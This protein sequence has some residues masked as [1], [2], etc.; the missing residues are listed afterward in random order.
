MRVLL[1][2]D[3]LPNVGGAERYI[4]CVRDGLRAAGD[5]VKLLTSTAGTAGD[6][7]AEYRAF[8]SDR[9]AAKLVLQLVNP[10]AIVAVRSALR[11]FRPDVALV[12]MFEHQL[13]PAVL[14]ALRGVPTVLCVSDYKGICPVST[15]LLPNGRICH[16]RDGLICWR[17]GCVSLPHWVRDQPRY[18]L[19]RSGR[20]G[21][22]RIL[23]C[24]RWVQRELALSGVEAEH[25]TLPV[26]A[27]GPDFRRAPAADPMFVFCGRL[28]QTKGVA[29]LLRAFARLRSTAPAAR[30][31]IVGTGP[32]RDGLERLAGVLGLAEAVTF[33]G[34]VR[35]AEVAREIADAWALVVPSL[36]AEPLGL[37]AIE[38]TVRGI[39]VVASA[40]GGL[41]EIVEHGV[42]G[43][44]FPNGDEEALAERLASI[45]AGAAFPRHTVS[46]AIVR[47]TIEAHDPALYTRC[48][49]GIFT[50]LTGRAGATPAPD[51]PL[52]AQ[53]TPEVGP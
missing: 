51:H 30:L 17:A 48:L 34:W 38:A 41:G 43:L 16:E 36:W 29:L 33:R 4:T 46:E 49:R 7:A 2:T 20:R 28:D 32:D 27:P 24:S 10:F 14:H 1:I 21:V 31:R 22:A 47:R 45:A 37:V 23:A 6:G 40:A 25:L 52:P 50:S 18:A 19:I 9:M 12:N 15:K 13:S 26:P 39:P 35:P 42:S 5:D 44:L 8:G 53:W 11:E 3:W